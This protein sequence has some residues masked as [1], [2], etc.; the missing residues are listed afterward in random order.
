MTAPARIPLEALFGNPERTSPQISP[1]GTRLAYLAPDAGVLNVWVRSVAKDDS[2]PVTAD[3]KRGI[4]TFFWQQDA[5][6]LFYVQDAD[7]D[8]NW[9]LY[10]VPAEG[11]PAKDLTP[12]P[13][14]QAHAVAHEPEFPGQ[15]LIALNRRDPRLHDV[16]RLSLDDGS[17]ELE[18]ENPGDVVGW[19]PDNA[20]R[21]RGARA[22]TPDGGCELRLRDGKDAPWRT[23]ETW[24]PDDAFGGMLG[25]GPD[26]KT[27]RLLTSVGANA[28][29]LVEVGPDG[30]EHVVAEDERYDVDQTMDHPRRRTLEAVLFRRD[31][32]EWRIVDPS[33]E[34][35]FEA[36]R[37]TRDGDFAVLSRDA[38]DKLWTVA[39]IVDD[40]PLAF[41]LYDR[42]ARKAELLF[43][44]RPALDGHALSKMRPISYPARDGLAIHGYLTLPKG[45]D[46]G[47]FP[48]VLNVHGG[49]WVRDNWGFNPEVQWLANRGYA[50]LQVNYRGSTGYGKAHVN[51]GDRE[52]GAKM[53]DDLIDAKRWAVSQGHATPDKVAIYGGTYGGYAVLAAIAFA[54]GEFCV[55]VDI[56]G[57]SNPVTAN[58][59]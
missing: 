28:A 14:V 37:R 51:A 5:R 47:P 32:R 58:P 31:R 55:G 59:V 25:F 35:D 57:P 30:A 23:L 34:A 21:V 53:L 4:R 50:V 12:Y 54:P 41:Y 2:R 3:R 1:D 56:V 36:L 46:R 9:H 11:G 42:T 39:Y 16:Y 7:G 29:R 49:P 38:A 24:G 15:I 18:A 13:G 45:K 8:E 6:H 27:L 33:I 10:R 19:T 20:L 48:L 26:N 52:W 44:D 22:A 40:G 43:T 17:L